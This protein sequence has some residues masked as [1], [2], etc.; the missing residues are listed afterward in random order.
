MEFRFKEENQH[1]LIKTSYISSKGTSQKEILTTWKIIELS[2]DTNG[3]ETIFISE[4]N[5]RDIKVSV[6]P[7][8]NHIRDNI[9]IFDSNYILKKLFENH[10]LE[11][12]IPKIGLAIEKLDNLVEKH[13]QINKNIPIEAIG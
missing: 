13:N 12:L 11:T 4:P 9:I 8:K 2:I 7:T 6:F 10:K 3:N 5:Q 1:L